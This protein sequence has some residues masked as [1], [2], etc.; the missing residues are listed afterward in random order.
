MSGTV[1]VAI[2]CI[3]GAIP[4][5][6]DEIIDVMVGITGESLGLATGS[7]CSNGGGFTDGP[8]LK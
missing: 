5:D 1:G 7:G 3:V 6:L 2:G 8:W 4:G